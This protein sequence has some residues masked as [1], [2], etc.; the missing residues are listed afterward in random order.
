MS[1][2]TVCKVSQHYSAD[3][4]LTTLVID[5]ETGEV[6]YRS[7]QQTSDIYAVRKIVEGLAYDEAVKFTFGGNYRLEE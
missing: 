4:E 6:L 3:S 7:T 2:E 1:E 5:V